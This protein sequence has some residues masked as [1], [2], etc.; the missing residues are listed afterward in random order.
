MTLIMG[1]F[2]EGQYAL[3]VKSQI[4]FLRMRNIS[5]KVYRE[6]R[7]TILFSFFPPKMVPLM[8]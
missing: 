5:D 7:N 1:T 4:M 2:L 3:M 8:R 6:N